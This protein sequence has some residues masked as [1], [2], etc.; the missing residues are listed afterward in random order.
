MNKLTFETLRQA[1]E[2]RLPEFKNKFGILTHLGVEEW[3]VAEWIMAVTGELGEFANLA[4]KHRR[5]DI[6]WKRFVEEGSKELADVQTYLDL[7]ACRMDV[8]LGQATVDKFNEVSQRVSSRVH[9]S[10]DGTEVMLDNSRK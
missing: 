5:G 2:A 3:T 1:N 9:I 10:S 7:L 4:K 6:S 8:D